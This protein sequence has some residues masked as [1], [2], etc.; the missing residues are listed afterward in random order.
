VL[1]R[2]RFRRWITTE[3]IE[4]LVAHL[5]SRGCLVEDEAEPAR[6][7]PDPKDDYLIELTLVSRA[8]ALVSGD[9]HLVQMGTGGLSVLTP[10]AFIDR[11]LGQDRPTAG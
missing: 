1:R 7:T 6:L 3:E 10:R 4:T 9:G 5:R 2:P 8:D 11:F